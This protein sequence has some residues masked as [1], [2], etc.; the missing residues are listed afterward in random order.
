MANHRKQRDDHD[1]TRL[2][3]DDVLAEVLRRLAPRS[4]AASRCVCKAWQAVID[5]RHLLRAD[6]LPLSLDGII[7]EFRMQVYSEFFSRPP[8]PTCPSISGTFEHLLTTDA[9]GKTTDH[10]NGLLL[11]SA[12]RRHDGKKVY[13]RSGEYV[14][15]PAKGWAAPLPPCPSPCFATPGD[16]YNK[17][18]VFDPTVSA[19]YEVFSV[20]HL[21]RRNIEVPEKPEWPPSTLIM[22]VFSSVS[23]RWEERSFSREGEPARLTTVV[24]FCKEEKRYAVN[25]HDNE[26]SLSRH[27]FKWNSTPADEKFE[28]NSN[29]DDALEDK[30]MTNVCGPGYLNILGFH[31]Y[32]EI[33][34][35]FRSEVQESKKE[36]E[37][38]AAPA[39]E[40]R[41]RSGLMT[42]NG[43][44]KRPGGDHDLV[45]LL[46]DDVLAHILGR[47]EP[48]WL[49]ACRC[50]CKAWHSVIDMRRLLR[51]DLLPLS[52]GGIIIHF[53][54]HLYSE[55]FS[56]PSTIISNLEHLLST[57]AWQAM[58]H[59]NGLLLLRD[60][61]QDVRTA[62][63]YVANPAKGWAAPLPPCPPPRLATEGDYYGYYL[64][65]DPSVSAHYEVFS[66]II[67][68]K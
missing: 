33:I 52:L 27:K 32:K 41:A 47:L 67:V 63:K 15:N 14:A 65:F 3:L 58:D 8:T 23:Q 39:A 43:K 42:S 35:K 49:A 30:D 20:P 53:Y 56:R 54:G 12:Y 62:A 64:A 68:K 10:C 4:L 7:I 60:G 26:E 40:Y 36:P 57:E 45:R 46:P 37:Q 17:Y 50:V 22:R 18:L 11:L 38:V 19:H 6:L 25:W 29:G 21:F 28:W 16:Y 1:L 13:R 5:T 24:Q 59:C 51:A 48:R 44:A 66:N 55:F 34:F 61:T 31:P 2:L 9:W